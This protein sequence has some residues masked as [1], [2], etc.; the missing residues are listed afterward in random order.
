MEIAPYH[1]AI[2][3]DGNR[4]WAKQHGL[5][6]IEGHRRGIDN[7]RNVLQWC[8]TLNI[9]MVTLWGFS[10]ENFDR[11]TDEVQLLMKLFEQKID[12]IN[13][14]EVHENRIKVRVFGRKFR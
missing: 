10:M 11:D 5:P 3:P 4:R 12:E 13:R 9:R 6:L 14:K 8:R 7:L 2:N 1:V